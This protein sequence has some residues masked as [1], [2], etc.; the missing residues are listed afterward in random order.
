MRRLINKGTMLP[1]LDRLR[2]TPT[3]EFYAL[4][5]PEV[6]ED[7]EDPIH[8]NPF[9]P[10][11]ARD[12]PNA[13]FRVRNRDPRPG[14]TDQYVYHFFEAAS[15]W[16]WVRRP[17][18]ATNPKNRDPFWKE[19][20]LA[21]HDRFDPNGTVPDW[22]RRLPQ[23]DPA[24]NDPRANVI[25]AAP[26]RDPDWAKDVIDAYNISWNFAN[27]MH[28]G[29]PVEEQLTEL[30]EAL[31]EIRQKCDDDL[32]GT[33]YRTPL[34]RYDNEGYSLG[35]HIDV[36]DL[37]NN[38][39]E[40]VIV[41]TAPFRARGLAIWFIGH[42]LT[43]SAFETRVADCVRDDEEND[44]NELRN[45]LDRFLASTARPVPGMQPPQRLLARLNALRIRHTTFWKWPILDSQLMGPPPSTAL[46][47]R[48][49]TADEEAVMTELEQTLEKATDEMSYFTHDPDD[50]EG[51]FQLPD[52]SHY[53][54]RSVSEHSSD[55]LDKLEAL[56]IKSD[57]FPD[58]G[59]RRALIVTLYANVLNLFVEVTMWDE[60]DLG[61][62]GAVVDYDVQRWTN[63]VASVLQTAVSIDENTFFWWYVAPLYET[64]VVRNQIKAQ[65]TVHLDLGDINKARE[66]LGRAF[67]RFGASTSARERPDGEATPGRRR[68]RTDA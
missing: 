53:A 63:K 45:G 22:V 39:L 35:V 26:A 7:P 33:N 67:Y 64:G 5:A 21:L 56:F 25:V 6:S 44:Q 55:T 30:R 40:I 49:L 24:F 43:L 34:M 16:D 62:W 27:N 10:D 14:T 58:D 2:L 59:R 11:Q 17:G 46:P 31:H 1:R 23:L 68:Q 42:F 38:L 37:I 41:R 65:E 8:G 29:N 61:H 57:H 20:W 50:V 18:K 28:Y 36:R 32:E 4:S 9:L 47:P 12:S 52:Y 15:L 66:E 3:G 48:A 60:A 19:D 13:T 51:F 54:A